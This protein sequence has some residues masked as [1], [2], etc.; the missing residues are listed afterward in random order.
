MRLNRCPLFLLAGILAL[1]TRL[2]LHAFPVGIALAQQPTVDI[3]TVTSSPLGPTITVNTD[4]NQINVRSGPATDYPIVGVLVSGQRAPALGRSAGGDWI[5]IVYPGVEGGVAW[6][7][8]PLVTVS[9][10]LP[11]V[12]PP[13]TPTPKVTPTIDPTLAAQFII[14]LEPTRLPTYTEPPPLVLAT[15]APP[16]P[17]QIT[18]GVPMGMIIA[19]L[20]ILGLFGLIVSFLRSR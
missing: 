16:N 12:E 11:I 10:S 19:G 8:A 17:V 3:P 7:Y 9:G 4:Q 1:F 18:R 14:E 13:P 15:F 5:V 2:V 20:G 6:V